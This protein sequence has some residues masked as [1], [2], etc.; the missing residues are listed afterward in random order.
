M[1]GQDLFDPAPEFLQGR[2]IG[3]QYVSP[4]AKAQKQ[5][6]LQSIMRAL[7]VMAQVGQFVPI[8]DYIDNE[9]LIDHLLDTLGVPAKVRKS[10]SEVQMAMEQRMVR[11]AQQQELQ[12]TA[13][14]AQ[15]AGQ[16][17]PALREVANIGEQELAVAE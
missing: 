6:D 14:L 5:T 9:G 2:D 3:I 4:L 1:I 13:V 15:A 8:L 7:E 17:A 12:Q 16:A 10:D 11:E